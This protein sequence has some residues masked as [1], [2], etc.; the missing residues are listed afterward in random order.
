MKIK[1]KTILW[2]IDRV[3]E[4]SSSISGFKHFWPSNDRYVDRIK[5]QLKILE[6]NPE[7][8]EYIA[9][10]RIEHNFPK[11]L[12]VDKKDKLS[13]LRLIDNLSSSTEVYSHAAKLSSK[14]LDGESHLSMCT[15]LVYN[16]FPIEESLL[17]ISC[18]IRVEKET[19]PIVLIQIHKK[20]ELKEFN[21][22]IKTLWSREMKGA[23]N[24]LSKVDL[25]NNSR[26]FDENLKIHESRIKSKPKPYK[27]I[28]DNI[29]KNRDENNE[30]YEESILRHRPDQI[31]KQIK[32]FR[33]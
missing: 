21:R 25:I 20:L 27:K 19:T 23:V 9:S 3:G 29:N 16:F 18:L 13:T 5:K 11:V 4:K 10:F 8:Q 33:S 30:I 31:K 32:K 22:Q 17:D 7:F 2:E 1:I 14:Y 6:T 24:K 15:Y 28:L 26:N 12:P